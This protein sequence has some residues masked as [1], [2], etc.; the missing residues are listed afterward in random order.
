MAVHRP[1]L[2]VVEEDEHLAR[3]FRRFLSER[4]F[5]VATA[6][7]QADCLTKLERLYPDAMLLDHELPNRASDEILS[8][9]RT[10]KSFKPTPVVMVSD[11]SPSDERWQ[12]PVVAWV[13]KPF[14]LVDI[15]HALGQAFLPMGRSHPAFAPIAFN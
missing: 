3:F 7:A 2:L 6:A 9:L 11:M 1:L 5:E 8:T 13:Q 14:R 10:G 12:S 15:V 4:G